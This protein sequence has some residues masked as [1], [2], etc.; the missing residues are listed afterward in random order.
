M[1]AK[2]ITI[3]QNAGSYFHPK[4]QPVTIHFLEMFSICGL[5]FAI[6]RMLGD[7][8]R[9]TCSEVSTGYAL[10]HSDCNAGNGTRIP[11]GRKEFVEYCKKT[12]PLE[13]W[14]HDAIEG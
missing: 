6:H 3:I 9:L 11:A 7:D 8:K 13:A 14:L 2:T 10:G 5:T 4:E 12:I 1:S